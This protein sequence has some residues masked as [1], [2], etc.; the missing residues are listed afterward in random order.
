MAS[1]ASSLFTVYVLVIPVTFFVACADRSNST[2]QPSPIAITPPFSPAP[3]PSGMSGSPSRGTGDG[4]GGN[5]CEGRPIES[6]SFQIENSEAY[7]TYIQPRIKTLL[8]NQTDISRLITSSIRDKKW[9]LLPCDLAR[10]PDEKIGSAV[11]TE[12]AALQTFSEVWMSEK[13][14]SAMSVRDQADLLLHE[15]L[16][17]LRL[18]K[19]DSLKNQCRAFAPTD[20]LAYCDESSNTRRGRPLDLTPDD[21]GDIRKATIDILAQPNDWTSQDLEYLLAKHNFSFETKSFRRSEDR[22]EMTGAEFLRKIKIA[23]YSKFLPEHSAGSPC[24]VEFSFNPEN[25]TELKM[26]LRIDAQEVFQE[27]YIVDPDARTMGEQGRDSN[28]RALQSFSP[29][30]KTLAKIK[31]GQSGFQS[32]F[33]LSGHDLAAVEIKEVSCLEG[34]TADDGQ[35]ACVRLATPKNMKMYSCAYSSTWKPTHP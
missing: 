22:Y 5:T 28:N 15:M 32:T 8:E 30:S 12:Q 33:Y 34:K 2:V 1:R 29:R 10:L 6:Y 19:L 26:V 7:K 16:M 21:Y 18:L 20:K 3:A 13:L 11:Q 4:G 9:Y 14:F 25:S 35:E 24:R 23:Q 31:E 27:I 17:G